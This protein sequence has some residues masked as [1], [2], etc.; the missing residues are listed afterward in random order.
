MGLGL[1][2]QLS[3]GNIKDLFAQA[4]SDQDGYITF[5]DVLRAMRAP[6]TRWKRMKQREFADNMA[7]SV[8][9]QK[10]NLLVNR[11]TMSLTWRQLIQ[12]AQTRSASLTYGP[13]AGDVHDIV[14]NRVKA[15][16]PMFEVSSRRRALRR[17]Y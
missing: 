13:L 2:M 15:P 9:V 10:W 12:R 14:D 4:D 17:K 6:V 16:F 8:D 5:L 1:N 3:E 11:G 7:R